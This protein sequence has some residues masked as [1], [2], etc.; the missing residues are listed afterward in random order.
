MGYLANQCDR[1]FLQYMDINLAVSKNILAAAVGIVQF[2]R[3]S[4][5]ADVAT[6]KQTRAD[7]A[8]GKYQGS[9]HIARPRLCKLQMP[10]AFSLFSR[11]QN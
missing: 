3:A 5:L 10:Y 4:S 2:N 8:V 11:L 9:K 1:H 6:K 7:I